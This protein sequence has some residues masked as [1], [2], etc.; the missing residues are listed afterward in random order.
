MLVTSDP[1]A[2][3]WNFIGWLMSYLKHP[4]SR[5]NKT[6]A[7]D[8]IREE[9][10]LFIVIFLYNRIKPLELRVYCLNQLDATIEFKIITER[11]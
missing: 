5:N 4:E 7:L 10:F 8:P 1:G 9:G 11:L 2:Q 3:G 6:Q